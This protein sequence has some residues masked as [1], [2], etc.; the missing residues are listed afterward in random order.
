MQCFQSISNLHYNI[1]KK[2][3][4]NRSKKNLQKINEIKVITL[5]T[6]LILFNLFSLENMSMTQH[7]HVVV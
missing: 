2:N 3:T 6:L 4:L 1:L 5:D 7:I